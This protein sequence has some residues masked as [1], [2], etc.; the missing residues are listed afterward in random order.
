MSNQNYIPKPVFDTIEEVIDQYKDIHNS[1]NPLPIIE[2]WLRHCFASSNEKLPEYAVK[3]YQMAL[4][5][6]YSYRGSHD[7]FVAYRRDLERFIQWS[8]FVREQSILNHKRDDIEA[9]VEFCL[10]PYKRWI[11]LK[12]VARF[13]NANGKKNPNPEWRP[14][15]A[16]VS[17]QDHKD[18]K[19]PDKNNYQ[20]SQQALKVMF[21]IALLNNSISNKAIL[22]LLK[23]TLDFLLLLSN[24]VAFRHTY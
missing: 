18:G 8:W 19:K 6:L 11:G 13:K 3:D 16:H 15:E 10:N 9:F 5:F 2:Q 23:N 7:T 24:C 14:F 17:K 21:G 1:D 22:P 4:S 20:F 12:K